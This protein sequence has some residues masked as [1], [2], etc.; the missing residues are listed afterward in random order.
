MCRSFDGRARAFY[1][2]P[3]CRIR[4]PVSND[5]KRPVIEAEDDVLLV[6]FRLCKEGYA[7][8]V[9]EAKE[10]DARTVLQALNYEKFLGDYEA[11]FLEINK[12]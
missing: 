10:L 7:S 2:R 4:T 11:A 12:P 6:Y 3:L 5:R 8:G 1:E 9:S